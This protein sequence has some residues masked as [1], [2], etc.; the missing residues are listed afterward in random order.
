MTL[1]VIYFLATVSISGAC[2]VFEATLFS[3]TTP[4]VEASAK[5]TQ[6]GKILKHLKANIDNSVGAVLVINMFANTVG[7]A[8]VGAQSVEVFGEEWA[9]VVAII[10]T[11]S[12]LYVAEIIPKTLG[13]LYWKKLILPLCYPLIMMYYVAFPF[14][15]ISRGITF[16][17]RKNGVEKISRD[18]ILSLMELG[19][20]SG[21]LD[22]LEM[23]I[24]EHIIG[25]KSIRVKNIM[26][27]KNLVFTLDENLT[28]TQALAQ[29]Q[30]RKYS[31]I[32][33]IDSTKQIT[34]IAYRKDILRSN[35]KN[36][37]KE[38]LKN[39]AK[40]FNTVQEN[41]QVLMLLRL[42][43][44]RHAHLFIVLD[45]KGDYIGIVTL[46]DALNAVLGVGNLS[47]H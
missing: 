18:E 4:F 6:A 1:L 23:D 45:K 27:P 47:R 40:P 11:I 38:I 28:L 8:A 21:S 20:K 12:I 2:S 15:Y 37:D 35:L 31:R 19:E 46:E 22:A 44:L 30:K 43:I 36:K 39:I 5:L 3:A 25:Q 9:G 42:F 41:K 24:L 13:A 17:F 34:S 32:P 26:T 29:S 33:L 10:M 14:V 7:A 16:F